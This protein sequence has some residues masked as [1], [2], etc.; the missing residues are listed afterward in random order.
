MRL[1]ISEVFALPDALYVQ[2]VI[3][4]IMSSLPL[5]IDPAEFWSALLADDI[6]ILDSEAITI[7]SLALGARHCARVVK[8]SNPIWYRK[9]SQGNTSIAKLREIAHTIG[10]RIIRDIESNAPN[11]RA[12]ARFVNADSANL[13]LDSSFGICLT[14][15]PYLNRL[16][17]AVAHL[18]ELSVLS[19]VIPLNIE[20]LRSQM[21]GTTKIVAK[22]DEPIPDEWGSLCKKVLNTIRYHKSYASERY[23]YFTF[24]QY[25]A[26]LYESLGSLS[27]VMD[28]RSQGLMVLQ[29]SYYKDLNVPTQSIVIDMLKSLLWRAEIVRDQAVKVHMGRMNPRQSKYAPTKTLHESIVYFVR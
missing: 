18:P 14:S 25:F 1:P 26:R 29:D 12:H 17:Y 23:Y 27:K 15:P 22:D 16:D 8:G 21:I 4:K 7:L 9:I 13:E 2:G 24:K 10:M 11:I 28:T 19:Y 3:S 20:V 5:A 6:G